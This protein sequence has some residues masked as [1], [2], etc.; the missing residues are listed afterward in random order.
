MGYLFFA[1]RSLLTVP[2]YT[3]WIDKAAEL[4]VNEFSSAILKA[5]GKRREKLKQST[6]C[7]L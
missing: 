5:F 2:L 1:I 7:C 4:S 3:R 6:L